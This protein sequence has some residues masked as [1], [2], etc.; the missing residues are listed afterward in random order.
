MRPT[1]KFLKRGNQILSSEAGPPMSQRHHR[2]L[3]KPI[4]PYNLIGYQG[5]QASVDSV[6]G[7]VATSCDMTCLEATFALSNRSRS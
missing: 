1:M 7:I 2:R 3:A 4:L 6:T 5:I